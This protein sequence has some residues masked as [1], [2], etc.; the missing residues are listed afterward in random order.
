MSRAE[1]LFVE[2]ENKPDIT[3]AMIDMTDKSFTLLYEE[4]LQLCA[5]AILI[6]RTAEIHTLCTYEL[7]HSEKA[8][9]ELFRINSHRIVTT[10]VDSVTIHCQGNDEMTVEIKQISAVLEV[11]CECSVKAANLILNRMNHN[12][13][14]R[15]RLPR[16]LYQANLVLLQSLFS[17]DTIEH[18]NDHALTDRPLEVKL[19]SIAIVEKQIADEFSEDKQRSIQ[20]TEMTA[21]ITNNSKIYRSLSDYITYK[22]MDNI[23]T[24]SNSEFSLFRIKDWLMLTGVAI[25]FIFCCYLLFKLKTVSA[26]LLASIRVANG[27]LLNTGRSTPIPPSIWKI[28]RITPRPSSTAELDI[29]T[30]L[31]PSVNISYKDIIAASNDHVPSGTLILL[32]WV[33]LILLFVVLLYRIYK[34]RQYGNLTQIFLEIKTSEKSIILPF[35]SLAHGA[36]NYKIVRNSGSGPPRASV[37]LTTRCFIT[38]VELLG[39]IRFV[40]NDTNIAYSPL[41]YRY[42][43]PASAR[44]IRQIISSGE[45]FLALIVTN[46]SRTANK[47]LR[48]RVFGH[49]FAY[50]LLDNPDEPRPRMGTEGDRLQSC[51]ST[52]P[53]INAPAASSQTTDVQIEHLTAPSQSQM[54]SHFRPSSTG[55]NSPA[56]PDDLGRQGLLDMN[57]RSLAVHYGII[58]PGIG[59]GRRQM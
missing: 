56:G 23:N 12:C 46:R 44:T 35:G 32:I 31:E 50:Q 20:L 26:M 59:R 54:D 2:L 1:N 30:Q 40:E 4:P 29:K 43:S 13:T 16:I 21:A 28:L 24:E 49:G 25:E 51:I 7:F 38:K 42:I 14:A 37:R 47:I 34:R 19:P 17:A 55:T 48:L 8:P 3:T 53:V 11:G 9:P 58:N 5:Q 10:G 41:K 15:P 27:Q 57:R 22:I 18:I 45:Y 6:G 52:Q 39:R 36:G 33:S